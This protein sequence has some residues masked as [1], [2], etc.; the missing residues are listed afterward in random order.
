MTAPP[1]KRSRR[2]TAIPLGMAMA[3]ALAATRPASRPRPA[4]HQRPD[5]GPAD[6]RHMGL[7]GRYVDGVAAFIKSTHPHAPAALVKA[8]LYAEADAV[9]E[10][11]KNYNGFYGFG[12]ADALD[13]VTR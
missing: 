13:A 1:L 8:L 2:L 5:P 11:P 6:R 7:H 3:T 4:R 12:T 9:C 10:G